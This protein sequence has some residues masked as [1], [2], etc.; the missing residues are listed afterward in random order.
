MIAAS[1]D[2]SVLGGRARRHFPLTAQRH[3]NGKLQELAEV[4]EEDAQGGSRRFFGDMQ[5]DLRLID[6]YGRLLASEPFWAGDDQDAIEVGATVLQ[7][8]ND[9]ATM[10]QIRRLIEQATANAAHWPGK[11]LESAGKT[12]SI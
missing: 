3:L 9:V 8:C 1:R 5:Y 10:F 2:R 6:H 12:P 11:L 4:Q 7:A